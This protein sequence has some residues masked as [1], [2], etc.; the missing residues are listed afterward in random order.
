MFEIGTSLREA[1]ERRSLSYSQVE[2][3]TAIRSRYIRA[4]EDEE[5]HILPARRTPRAS[6]GRTPSTWGWTASCSWTSS[7]LATT[8]PARVVE[9]ADRVAPAVASARS[10]AAGASRTW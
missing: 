8:I 9:H 1:R 7:T 4:L 5:F 2:A 10:S 3:D 6:C